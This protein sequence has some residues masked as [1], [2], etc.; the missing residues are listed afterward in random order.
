L[1]LAD[2]AFS[3]RAPAQLAERLRIAEQAYGGLARDPATAASITRELEIGCS[4][5]CTE[6][7]N[8][9]PFKGGCCGP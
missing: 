6:I 2:R 9:L 7:R 3:F 1:A 5:G 8:A 4:G